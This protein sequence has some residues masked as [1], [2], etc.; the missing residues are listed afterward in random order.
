MTLPWLSQNM[1]R[2]IVRFLAGNLSGE[3]SWKKA[4]ISLYFKP[5]R[6]L[7]KTS[8]LNCSSYEKHFYN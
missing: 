8:S 3:S 1:R 4:K 2:T 6:F 7:S 5:F